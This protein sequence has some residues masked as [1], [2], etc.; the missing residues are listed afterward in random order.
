MPLALAFLLTLLAAQPPP[1]FTGTWEC[2]RRRCDF[3]R[4]AP[5]YFCIHRI[6]YRDPFFEIAPLNSK[7]KKLKDGAIRFVVGASGETKI[8][9]FP[10]RF[11]A[12]LAK[13]TLFVDRTG[14][15]GPNPSH[16]IE[17][18]SLSDGGLVLTIRR[19]LNSSVGLMDQ[20]IVLNRKSSLPSK[21]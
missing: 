1:D 16:V 14:L 4:E 21:P 17:S 9:S 5:P 2:D 3:D 18:Y 6:E 20:T 8:N 13:G 19:R 10:V 11:K 12:F 7:G 15:Y